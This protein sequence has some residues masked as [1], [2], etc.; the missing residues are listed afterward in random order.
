MAEEAVVV[1]YHRL[2]GG[3]AREVLAPAFGPVTVILDNQ[4]VTVHSDHGLYTDSV[5]P[6]SMDKNDIE[7]AIKIAARYRTVAQRV[8]AMTE[9]VAAVLKG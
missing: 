3:V 8:Q 7:G 2:Q 4:T 6:C 9:I 5:P 1:R